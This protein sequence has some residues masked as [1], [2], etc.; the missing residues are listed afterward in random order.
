MNLL[1]AVGT[2]MDGTGL[3]NIM[4]VVYGDNAALQLMTGK[5]V[6]RSFRGHLLVN[7]CLNHMIVSAIVN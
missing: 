4:E 1:V 5:S 7:N 2:L 3:T 6:E